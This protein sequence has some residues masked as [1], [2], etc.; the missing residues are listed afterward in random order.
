MTTESCIFEGRFGEI[1]IPDLLTFLDMIGKTGM[2]EVR[3]DEESKRVFWDGG[4]IVFADST[5][6]DEQMGGYLLRNGWVSREALHMAR[7]EAGDDERKLVAVLIREGELA[8]GRLPK[9]VRSLV[10]DIVYS[11]FDWDEGSFRF[12]VESEHHPEKVTLRTSVSNI[13][14]E[15]SRRLD[16]WR[17]F[18]DVFPSDDLHPHPKA[19]ET[20]ASV[21]LAP[22]EE[23]ILGHVD[24]RRSIAQL[25]QLVDHDQFTTLSAL[26]ALLTAG[27][28]GVSREPVEA[29]GAAS[30]ATGGNGLSG[31]E[32]E[33]A[34]SILE[35]FN[36]IFAGIH[37]R[38]LAVKGE[39][40]RE[41]FSAT[42][43]KASFQ[44]VGVFN[45]VQFT[46]EGRLPDAPV[47]ENVAQ[48]P[49]DE[50]LSRLK[51]SMDRLL[52]QQVL[53]MDT[54]YPTEE[55]KAIS[56]LIAREKSRINV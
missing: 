16:E 32:A 39:Q 22:I 53:Q 43:S 28:I 29:A 17:R 7:E 24:G 51:G 15:G 18:R 52:A 2:L 34:S 45:G 20:P 40:G 33:A 6:P 55:K 8:P 10:L 14:M 23:E 44:K 13:I 30:A 54:S 46:E 42:L 9:A 35:A 11:L 19:D 21:K 38:V 50:R 3:R 36:N 56:D 48:L 12:V 49:S 25:I 41:R 4:S 47:L 37:E 31:E 1:H 5:N 26:H 27:F